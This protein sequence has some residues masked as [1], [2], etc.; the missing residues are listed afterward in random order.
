VG[1]AVVVVAAVVTTVVVLAGRSG[2]PGSTASPAPSAT[3][4]PVAG[5]SSAGAPTT[6]PGPGTVVPA[7][8]VGVPPGTMLTPMASDTIAVPGMVIDGADVHGGL[9]VTAPG[10]IIRNSRITGDGSAPWGV[11]AAADGATVTIEDCTFTGDFTDA[12]LGGDDYVARRLDIYGVTND[13]G[14]LGRNT[15]VTDSWIHDFSTGPDAHG[16]GLQITE[17]VGNVTVAGN[18]I[19]VGTGPGANSALFL[20]PDV[21][22]DNPAAG[23]VTVTGNVLGGGGYAL[24]VTSGNGGAQLHQ[25]TVTGNK[26]MPD[27]QYGPVYPTTSPAVFSGNVSTKDGSVVDYPAPR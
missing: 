13:G 19:D 9:V 25:V 3:G 16:D 10:V 4:G 22:A 2:N 1:A 8:Q 11:Q 6:G 5:T 17:P 18:R 23:P 20:V 14:K 27:S 24:Y 12:A 7:G 21:G 15:S 26:F